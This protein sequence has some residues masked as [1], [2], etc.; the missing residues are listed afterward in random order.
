[1]NKIKICIKHKLIP[2]FQEKLVFKKI[3]NYVL[4]DSLN[5]YFPSI[6]WK[7]YLNLFLGAISYWIIILVTNHMKTTELSYG[8]Y[9]VSFVT[10]QVTQSYIIDWQ[11][12]KQNRIWVLV[13][14]L[15]QIIKRH[16]KEWNSKKTKQVLLWF[17]I[18]IVL[19]NTFVNKLKI[20]VMHWKIN[21]KN[22]FNVDIIMLNIKF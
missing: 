1:M 12:M 17:L 2:N 16:L 9:L 7:S 14:T 21:F 19:S 13:L 3:Y 4:Q 11:I 15:V 18:T 20:K 22:I 8:R 5:I 10:N 6:I